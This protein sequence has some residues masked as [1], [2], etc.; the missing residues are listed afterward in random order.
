MELPI[1][2][3]RAFKLV[4]GEGVV[5]FVGSGPSCDAG[6]PNWSDLIRCVAV[7]VGLDA[8]ISPYLSTGRLLEAAQFLSRSRSEE[9]IQERVAKEIQRTARPGRVHELIVGA[10]FS[11]IV[12]TNY[13]LLL[14]MADRARKFDVPTTHQSVTVRDH[15]HRPFVL[16]L[17]GHVNE[18]RTIVLSRSGYDQIVAPAGAPA[19]QFLYSTLGS[20]TLLFIGFGFRDPNIDAILREGSELSTIG[21]SSVFALVPSGPKIDHVL[22]ANLR[23]R[24]VNPIYIEDRGDHGTQALCEWLESLT[25]AV[26]RVT[27][28]RQ[29]PVRNAKPAELLQRIQSLLQSG[30]WRLVL[31][32]AVA[33]LENRPDL[34]NLARKGFTN[35]DIPRLFDQMSIGETRRILMSV[36]RERRNE[37]VEDALSCFPPG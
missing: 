6:V 22:D 8:E 19:R 24:K 4:G 9:D 21:G 18:P 27:L 5:A 23:T 3:I 20:F 7:D 1:D 32:K 15:L 2:L 25:R 11:G 16:H 36:N 34:Q 26:E 17:H 10:P 13:D 30:D 28:S 14:S 31:A 33:E 29:S 12:T 35:E 37:V